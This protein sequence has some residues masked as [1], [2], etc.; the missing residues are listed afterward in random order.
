[1][2]TFYRLP[3][4]TIGLSCTVFAVLRLV[5]DRRTDGQMDGTDLAK[6]GTMHVTIA[7]LSGNFLY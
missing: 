2:V 7:S 1:M 3:I 5:M 6:S 4:V